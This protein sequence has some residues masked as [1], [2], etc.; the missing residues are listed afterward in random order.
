MYRCSLYYSL[1]LTVVSTFKR[2]KGK[3]RKGSQSLRNLIHLVLPCSSWGGAVRSPFS[4][5]RLGGG[6]GGV[7]QRV[8]S[9]ETSP[10]PYR[11]QLCFQAAVFNLREHLV[12]L[13]GVGGCQVALHLLQVAGC[14]KAVF[15][16]ER[17]GQQQ[18]H[19]AGQSVRWTS[20]DSTERSLSPN[21]KPQGSL[22]TRLSPCPF[23]SDWVRFSTKG[24]GGLVTL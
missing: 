15:Q 24:T 13:A 17:I 4:Q 8:P 11:V 10:V 1:Y 21:S 12:V 16:V 7:G 22:G 23:F 5:Q 14:Q 20:T 6:G 18:N 2:R 9:A 19:P 3:G